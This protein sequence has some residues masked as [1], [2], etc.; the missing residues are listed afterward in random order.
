VWCFGV[1]GFRL[2][3]GKH[4]DL[5]IWGEFIKGFHFVLVAFSHV[6]EGVNGDGYGSNGG[7]DWIACRMS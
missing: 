6:L 7:L 1:D 5:C 3:V 4:I 2:L